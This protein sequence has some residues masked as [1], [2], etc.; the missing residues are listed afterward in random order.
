MPRGI[1]VL[2]VDKPPFIPYNKERFG[3]GLPIKRYRE[4]YRSGHNGLDSKSSKPLTGP[5]G[6]NPTFSA[7]SPQATY[8]LRRLFHKSHR[9]AHS[10]ASPFP[11]KVTL[12]LCCSL[13]NAL[14]TLRLATNLFRG[15]E[16]SNLS[17]KN[18]KT[19]FSS[20]FHNVERSRL[21]YS[22]RL[23]SCFVVTRTSCYLTMM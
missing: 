2:P 22:D 3:A 20:S 10:A 21:L 11:K 13:V 4:K 5:V 17:T 14:A 23:L 7:T 15:Y 16:G 12:R 6:S 19:S 1:T 9:R 8:R 18:V